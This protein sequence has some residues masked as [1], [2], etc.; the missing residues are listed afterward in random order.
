MPTRG[1]VENAANKDHRAALVAMRTKIARAIDDA[2]GARDLAGLVKQMTEVLD[3]I[4]ALDG[5]KPAEVSPS[6]ELT[7]R[8]EA[9][10]TGTSAS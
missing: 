8:R 3:K 5:A 10:R 4:A 1:T 6:D 9:R 7:K 2:P